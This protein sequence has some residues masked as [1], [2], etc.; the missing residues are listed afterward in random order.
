MSKIVYVDMVAD[1]FHKNHVELLKEAKSL[2]N[3]L[4]VGIH[5]DE[6]VEKYKRIPIISMEDRISVIEA[7]KYVDKVIH[8]APL[9]IT[10]EYIKKHNIDLIVHAHP[11]DDHS[12][13][14]GYKVPMEMNKFKRLSYHTGIS[15][16]EI[17]RRCKKR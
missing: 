1:L 13:D 16:S 2:G 5:S 3:I 11:I 6:S 15:T 14:E 9:I 10:E 12:Y 4:Y 8:D 17:I 7:C